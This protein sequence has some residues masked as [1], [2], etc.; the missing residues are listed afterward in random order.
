MWYSQCWLLATTGYIL[1]KKG[2]EDQEEK[3]AAVTVC[4][5]DANLF[6]FPADPTYSI[7]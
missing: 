7:T 2:V 5:S 6:T 4:S 3:M 1:Y